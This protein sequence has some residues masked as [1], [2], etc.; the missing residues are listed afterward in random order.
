MPV[1]QMKKLSWLTP[2]IKANLESNLTPGA[3]GPISAGAKNPDYAVTSRVLHAKPGLREEKHTFAAM[4][5][6]PR[7]AGTRLLLFTVS[8]FHLEKPHYPLPI[9]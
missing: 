1:S 9:R 2:L 5:P 3:G 7:T 8:L 4:L 6:P